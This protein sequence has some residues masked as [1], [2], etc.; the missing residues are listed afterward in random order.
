M[1]KLSSQNDVLEDLSFTVYSFQNAAAM[2]TIVDTNIRCFGKGWMFGNFW[3]FPFKSFE[4]F[5]RL[6]Y[7]VKFQDVQLFVF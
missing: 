2:P 5:K 7:S 6:E 4:R 3:E 1:T